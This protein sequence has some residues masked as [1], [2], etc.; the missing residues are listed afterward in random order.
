MGI[1]YAK[2]KEFNRAI[3]KFNKTIELNP[4]SASAYFNL[5]MVYKEMGK[6]EKMRE[7]L[8]KAVELNPKYKE[9]LGFS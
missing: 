1:I 9:R 3:K 4:K 2:K 6:T 8:E 5:G 7:F